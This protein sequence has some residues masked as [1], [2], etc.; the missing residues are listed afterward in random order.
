MAKITKTT[1][2]YLTIEVDEPWGSNLK[3]WSWATLGN[4]KS[5]ELQ[6][7]LEASQ[8]HGLGCVDSNTER[9]NVCSLCGAEWEAF[10]DGCPTCCDAAQEEWGAERNP[11]NAES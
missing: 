3:P 11:P 1:R 5:K 10:E 6:R 7:L 8:I 9:V 4:T 2:V